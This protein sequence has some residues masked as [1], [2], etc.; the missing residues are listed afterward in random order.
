MFFPFLQQSCGS[1]V[2]LFLIFS[3]VVFRLALLARVIF[4]IPAAS[5]K[6]ERVFSVA[7]RVVTPDR[8]R[9][10]PEMVEDLVTLKCNLRLLRELPSI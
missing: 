3:F 6:S 7:G 5:S 1:S 2:I 10:A 4:P 9:L 8:N